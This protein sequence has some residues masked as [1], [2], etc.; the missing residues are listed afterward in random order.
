MANFTALENIHI[1]IRERYFYTHVY[2]LLTLPKSIRTLTFELG[3]QEPGGPHACLD[4]LYNNDL[5]YIIE[6]YF[7]NLQT[8]TFAPCYIGQDFDEFA[9][10]TIRVKFSGLNYRGM[11]RVAKAC[12]RREEFQYQPESPTDNVL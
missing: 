2:L 1:I 10:E 4:G 11:L 7:P 9:C 5:E 12:E 8:V 3:W 6:K